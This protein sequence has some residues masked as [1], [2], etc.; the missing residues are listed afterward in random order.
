MR[1]R[2]GAA[3]ITAAMAMGA[4]PAA[5]A[6]APATFRESRVY[7]ACQGGESMKLQNTHGVVGWTSQ[8]PTRSVAD[9]A[10]CGF[11]D[12][13]MYVAAENDARIDAVYSGQVVGNL[14]NITVEA[15]LAG[16]APGA[17]VS[18]ELPL[19]LEVIIDGNED[20]YWTE[21]EPDLVPIVT[22]DNGVT[23][24]AEFTVTVEPFVTQE[25]GD[26]TAVHDIDLVVS[27]ARR[28]D[29]ANWVWGA[30]E[31]AGGLTFNDATPS[32]V[33]FGW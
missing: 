21:D 31:V 12:H 15:W 23:Y 11:A 2:A 30:R 10:G 32:P 29:S 3:I 13:G 16:P 25:A 6:A 17:L 26:G 20:V 27:P 14:R 8:G 4:S 1:R 22:A 33:Q 19:R 18:R 9:G 24:K 7:F 5:Q 28:Y